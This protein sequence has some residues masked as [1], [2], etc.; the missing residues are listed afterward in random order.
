MPFGVRGSTCAPGA[1]FLRFGGHTSCVAVFGDSDDVPRLI[2]DAGTG[3]RSL[4][5]LMRGQHFDGDILLTHLHWD[6]VQ[7]LPFCPSIDHAKARVRLHVPVPTS[8][9]AARALLG[10][11]LSPPHFPVGPDEFQGS[12]QFLP[13]LPGRLDA[14]V[15]VASIEHKGGTA[16]GIR[17]TID[18]RV[19]AYIP[20]HALTSNADPCDS[21]VSVA[22]GAN[23]LL[24]DGQFISDEFA[25]ARDFGH[26]TIESAMDFADRC[27]VDRLLLTHHDPNRTDSELDELAANFT[28]T[29][30]GRPVGF[31]CQDELV[32]V[33]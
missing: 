11:G 24:H 23:V 17:V 26:A 21:A 19:L 6:H 33:P 25:V 15:T 31:A 29:P 3:L 10:R 1:D 12:W 14:A 18:G 27:G 13:L 9:T 22:A 4:P 32:L 2:L 5:R 20:D 30:K 8:M 28:R 16:Y 7:G